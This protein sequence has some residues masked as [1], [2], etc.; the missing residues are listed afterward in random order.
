MVAAAVVE[1]AVVVAGSGRAA[2][3]TLSMLSLLAVLAVA[4]AMVVVR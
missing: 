3:A 4:A 1:V 2:V